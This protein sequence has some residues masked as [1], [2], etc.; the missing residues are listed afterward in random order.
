MSGLL[1]DF[2]GIAEVIVHLEN[3][4]ATYQNPLEKTSRRKD[5]AAWDQSR[6]DNLRREQAECS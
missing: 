3:L 1:N 5:T 6:P 2:L 4:R